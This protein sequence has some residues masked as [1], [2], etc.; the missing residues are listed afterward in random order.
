MNSLLLDV[1]TA[2]RFFS[3]R[4]AAFV[5]IVFTMALALGANTAV[6]SVLKAFVFSNLAVPESDRVVI[7][8]TTKDL[9]GRGRV[10][11]NDAY[12]NYKLLKETTRSYETIGTSFLSDVNWQQPEETRRLQGLRVTASFFEVMR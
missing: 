6:F 12:V 3:R 5:V 8:W 9:P 2:L 10:N 11:F 1:S 4:R 7:V